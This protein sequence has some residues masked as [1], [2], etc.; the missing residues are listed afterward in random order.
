MGRTC[1]K[2]CFVTA[3]LDPDY[4]I[5]VVYVAFFASFDLDLEVNPSYKTQIAFLKINEIPISIFFKYADFTDV[6][7]KDL[8]TKLPEYTGINNHVIKLVA[9]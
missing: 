9:G 6:F 1:W 5:F 7:S 8:A 2:K 3:I 4:N